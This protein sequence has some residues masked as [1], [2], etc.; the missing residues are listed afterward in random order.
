MKDD[1]KPIVGIWI[2]WSDLGAERDDLSQAELVRA[3]SRALREND[4][5]IL[6]KDQWPDIS[7]RLWISEQREV[8]DKQ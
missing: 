2:S 5:M 1:K 4:M 6:P 8:V 7:S 3:A